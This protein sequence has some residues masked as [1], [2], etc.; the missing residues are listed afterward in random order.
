MEPVTAISTAIITFKAIKELYDK[1]GDLKTRQ[2]F[3]DMQEQ[4]LDAKQAALEL[5]EENALL[6][7]ELKR[8]KATEDMELTLRDDGGCYAKDG[9][10]PYCPNCHRK[11]KIPHLMHSR[12]RGDPPWCSRCKYAIKR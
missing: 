10:G 1:A 6:K 5:R 8:V 7:E 4:L 3:M 9:S 12:L 2:L 11:D